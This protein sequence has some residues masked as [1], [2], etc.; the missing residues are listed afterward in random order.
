VVGER[1]EVEREGAVV[2]EAVGAGEEGAVLEKDIGVPV[3]LREAGHRR[4]QLAL[5]RLGRRPD[6][7][8]QLDDNGADQG[9]P[10]GGARLELRAQSRH[11]DPP[12]LHGLAQQRTDLVDAIEAARS[13]DEG[14]HQRSTPD[15]VA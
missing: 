1:V 3:D 12:Q 11:G 7:V 14:T 8:L 6:P 5:P 13:V 10:P 2:D 9:G 15:P 4:H